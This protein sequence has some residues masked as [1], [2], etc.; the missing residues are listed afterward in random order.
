MISHIFRLYCVSSVAF[1]VWGLLTQESQPLYSPF[2]N[3]NNRDSPYSRR[4]ARYSLTACFQSPRLSRFTPRNI[5]R[6]VLSSSSSSH[7]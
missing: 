3:K 7:R 5:L 2:N 6:V 4:P 1:F